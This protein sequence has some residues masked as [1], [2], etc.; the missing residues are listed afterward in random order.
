M[1]PFTAHRHGPHCKRAMPGNE[2]VYGLEYDLDD[3]NIVAVRHFKTWARL[4]T[5]ASTSFNSKLVLCRCGT[6][7]TAK[8]EPHREWVIAHGKIFP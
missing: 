5:R 3:S 8:L 6:Q 4:E 1:P 2:R 7:R